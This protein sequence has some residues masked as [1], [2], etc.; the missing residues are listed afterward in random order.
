MAGVNLF[1]KHKNSNDPDFID[2][3]LDILRK[4]RNARRIYLEYLVMTQNSQV[5]IIDFSQMYY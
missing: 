2:K 1:M 4:F 5:Y 3:A